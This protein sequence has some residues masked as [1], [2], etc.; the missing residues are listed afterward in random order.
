[1]S[2]LAQAL[3]TSAN[4]KPSSS[5][6]GE[7]LNQFLRFHLLPDM[8]ALIPMEQLT[9]ILKVPLSQIT[10]IS[11]LPAWVMGVYNW[12]GEILWLIDLGNLVGLTPWHHQETLSST[13]PVII[14]EAC[15]NAE[16]NEGSEY[17]PLG[18]LVNRVEDI[19]WLNP[20][21]LQSPPTSVVTDALAPFLCGYWLDAQG[22]MLSLLDGNAILDRLQ[23]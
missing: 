23:T 14:M 12:R 6:S 2:I 9:E 17:L 15:L 16:G 8:T 19:E 3:S 11:H 22:E 7:T 10:P 13:A 20:D 5:G 18:L 4:P 1:M 21:R